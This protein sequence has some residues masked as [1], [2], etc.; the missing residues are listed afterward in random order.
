MTATGAGCTRVGQDVRPSTP[1]RGGSRVLDGSLLEAYRWPFTSVKLPLAVYH[2]PVTTGR[3]PL[4]AYL[5]A[6]P[7]RPPTTERLLLAADD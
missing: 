5:M 1:V 7:W 4:A 2:W 6:E 3:L